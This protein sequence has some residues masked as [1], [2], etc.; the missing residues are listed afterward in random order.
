MALLTFNQTLVMAIYIL[1]GFILY[2]LHIV[3]EEGTKE[4]LNT[5]IYLVVPVIMVKS[6]FIEFSS[7]KLQDFIL[8]IGFGFLAIALAML[9]SRVFFNKDGF[10]DFGAS[11][12]NLGF[13][14]IPLV[15][16]V[17][18]ESAVFF[19][20]GILL[21]LNIGQW[22]YG[23]FRLTGEKKF[24]KIKKMLLNQFTIAGILGFLIFILGLGN[25]IPPIIVTCCNGIS[26][27][28]APIGMIIMG[29][30]VANTDFSMLFKNPKCIATVFVRLILIPLITI[31][32]LK[33]LPGPK[34]VKIAIICSASTPVGANLAF[35][36]NLYGKDYKFGAVCVVSST[37][38]CILTL[39]LMVG[40]ASSIL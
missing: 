25:K 34:E 27:L 8:S 21:F 16:A 1:L 17:L 38:L 4:F 22:T 20:I 6:F 30:Y 11:Y 18:G 2:K 5:L 9:I 29:A 36:A 28:N 3:T 15:T 33:V 24:I 12:G 23:I 26:A 40:F 37:I 31:L 32:A 13:F 10:A 39:P 35:Y 14:G 7:E 19:A